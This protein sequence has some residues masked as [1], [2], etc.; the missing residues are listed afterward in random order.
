MPQNG[1]S[2]PPQDSLSAPLVDDSWILPV[3]LGETVRALC[4]QP[5]KDR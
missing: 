5:Q 4:G 3:T 1:L 2:V